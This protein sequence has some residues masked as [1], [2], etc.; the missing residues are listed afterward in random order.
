MLRSYIAPDH[1]VAP[2]EIW[3]VELPYSAKAGSRVVVISHVLASS[4]GG[5]GQVLTVA[6]R[7][8]ASAAKSGGRLP[9]SS[10][11]GR[12]RVDAVTGRILSSDFSVLGVHTLPAP[13]E[14]SQSID[15][16]YHADYTY[17]VASGNSAR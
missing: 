2:G 15:M 11:D 12:W 10:A 8:T 3:R 13:P 17:N 7:I 5:A 14:S 16:S 9:F 1:P 6:C 4:P